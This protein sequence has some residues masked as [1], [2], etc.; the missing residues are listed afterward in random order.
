MSYGKWTGN[1]PSFASA[2]II[3]KKKKKKKK[4]RGGG[5]GGAFNV[6]AQ[7]SR[8]QISL[9][10]Q[11]KPKTTWWV[12]CIKDEVTGQSERL[13]TR[14]KHCTDRSEKTDLDLCSVR[15]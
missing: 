14:S 11:L 1:F 2:I 4:K 8:G 6:S 15:C 10:L 3:I 13:F 12:I 9:D 5:G 7:T